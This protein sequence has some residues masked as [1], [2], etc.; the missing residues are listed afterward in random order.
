MG[1][2]PDSKKL[3]SSLRVG[4]ETNLIPCEFAEAHGGLMIG[5]GKEVGGP[6]QQGGWSLA[7]TITP[8]DETSRPGAFRGG[9]TGRRT[10]GK[11]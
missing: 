4:A 11:E 9:M 2:E 10:P 6:S 5:S 7:V 1:K 8:A 3:N